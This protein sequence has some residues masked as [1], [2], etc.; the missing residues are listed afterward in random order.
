MQLNHEKHEKEQIHFISQ[1]REHEVN[2]GKSGN[3]LAAAALCIS[4][5]RPIP[6]LRDRWITPGGPPA[7][8]KGNNYLFAGYPCIPPPELY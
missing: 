4:F 7:V 8:S 1:A 2:E 5:R 6:R 3:A